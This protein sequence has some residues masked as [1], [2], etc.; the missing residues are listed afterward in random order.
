MIFIIL[1]GIIFLYIHYGLF[2]TIEILVWITVF[3]VS[4]TLLGINPHSKE[5]KIIRIMSIIALIFIIYFNFNSD[6]YKFTVL[7]LSIDKI[8]YLHEFNKPI[9]G[10]GRSSFIK[11]VYL[12]KN[13]DIPTFIKNLDDDKNYIVSI[14]FVPGR[15]NY[16]AD[17]P[18]LILSRP[19]LINKFSSPTLITKF[20]FERL[21]LMDI[22]F[23]LDEDFMFNFENLT[24]ESFILMKFS[25]VDIK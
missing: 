20:I 22:Y 21:D 8:S 10:G 17:A 2:I 3:I 6:H 23:Q 11:W 15:S 16:C 1:I 19:F 7:A 13:D 5:L 25:E 12:N 14:E 4:N 24:D 9:S 18:E